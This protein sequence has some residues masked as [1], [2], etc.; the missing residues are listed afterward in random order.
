MRFV[1]IRGAQKPS[2]LLEIQCALIILVVVLGITTEESHHITHSE[3][4]GSG[5]TLDRGIGQFTLAILQR[6]DSFFDCAL[7][8][9][10]VD[11]HVDGLVQAVDTVNGLFF[12][13][14]EVELVRRAGVDGGVR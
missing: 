4:S 14:L 12:D 2:R 9:H 3:L 13:E 10:L 1:L 7:D 11:F 6:D 5:L 8:Y